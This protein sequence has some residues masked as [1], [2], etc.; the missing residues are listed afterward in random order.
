MATGDAM[1]GDGE[2]VRYLDG[3]LSSRHR[4]AFD[5]RLSRDEALRERVSLLAAGERPFLQAFDALLD[6]APVERLGANLPRAQPARTQWW[7]DGGRWWLRPAAL[8]AG[9]A[10]LLIGASGGVVGTRM[11]VAPI[12]VADHDEDDAQAWRS[13]VV[14]YLDLTT[15]Q[16]LE[17][18]PRDAATLASD[19]VKVS[20]RVKLP[21][22]PERIGLPG[23][24]IERVD[25]YYY[26]GAPLAQIAYLDPE[27]G[28]IAFCA[29]S[30]EGEPH[31]LE[32]ERR[33]GMNV[34]YWSS[35]AHAF[36]LAGRAP[37]E[38]LQELART[39]STQVSS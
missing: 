20:K 39:L 2:V 8:A 38:I 4:T 9:L 34:A 21:L 15:S 24:S 10:V 6:E 16:A 35:G 22:T 12:E 33:N 23:R 26:D 19:L 30:Q 29:L 28:P 18:L 3:A 25:L 31:P 7:P 11:L 27:S 37:P 13:V 36:M 1:P 32:V 14:N 5:A 17:A